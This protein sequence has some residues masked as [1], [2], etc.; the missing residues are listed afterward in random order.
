MDALPSVLTWCYP[1]LTLWWLSSCTG[2]GTS[3]W[4][5]VSTP[6]ADNILEARQHS[7]NIHNWHLNLQHLDYNDPDH[8][9]ALRTSYDTSKILTTHGLQQIPSHAFTFLSFNLIYIESLDSIGFSW[10]PVSLKPSLFFTKLHCGWQH[11]QSPHYV[12]SCHCNLT[13]QPCSFPDQSCSSPS[14]IPT[15]PES[16][17]A[18]WTVGR[19]CDWPHAGFSSSRAWD[20]SCLYKSAL[21]SLFRSQLMTYFHSKF[22]VTHEEV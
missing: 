19:E 22:Q 12:T 13:S 18:C 11:L 21:F 7:T 9:H 5:A 8:R 15:H 17:Q 16:L 3:S 6:P 4:C 14:C 10:F 20:S 1:L 2:W